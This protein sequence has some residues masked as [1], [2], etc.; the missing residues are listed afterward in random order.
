MKYIPGKHI[1]DISKRY[2]NRRKLISIIASRWD[3]MHKE[4]Y[5]GEQNFSFNVLNFVEVESV[6]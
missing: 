6:K 1:T 5:D 2:F 4:L 3:Y